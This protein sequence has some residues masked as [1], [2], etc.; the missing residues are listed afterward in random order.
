MLNQVNFIGNVGRIETKELPQGQ[1]VSK[2]SLA[3]NHKTK[4]GDETLWMDISTW[5]KLAGLC[6][7]YLSKGKKVFVSGRLTSRTYDN[8]EGLKVTKYEV[9][10]N[11]VVFLSPKGDGSSETPKSETISEPDDFSSIP[12]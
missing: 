5:D 10:A 6:E 3:I 8:K 2:F 7:Q 1:K 11:Q 12:F 9:T 4:S